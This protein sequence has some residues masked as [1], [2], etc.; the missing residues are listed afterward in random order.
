MLS[1]RVRTEKLVIKDAK[2]RTFIA[3]D[4]SRDEMV[5][6]VYDTTAD[7]IKKG[8]D[9]VVIIDDSIVRGTTLEKS[10]L[11]IVDRLEP[12]KI[13]IVSSC[14][15]IRYPDCYGIDMSKI[16]D[17]VAF[18]AMLALLKEHHLESKLEEVY[19]KCKASIVNNES[20][21]VNYVQELYAPFTHQQ[22]SDKVAE[23]IRPV[24]L[25]ADLEVVFQTVEN[26]HVACPNH[27]GDWYFTGNYPTPGGNK[28]VNKAFVNFMEG[29]LV[30][31]Y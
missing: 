22:I 29:K 5:S 12:K 7:V 17:F 24:N 27:K 13:V 26:L 20:D 18:R 10:I 23:I 11:K 19:Q 2:N 28:V 15:Q 3:S 31:A 21:K 6:T 1:I 30:R 9:S 16:K 8:V 4:D 25:K 14:P